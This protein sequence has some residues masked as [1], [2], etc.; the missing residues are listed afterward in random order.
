MKKIKLT[1]N[2]DGTDFRGF[3]F[4]PKLRTV[5]GEI[6]RSLSILTGEAIRVLGSGR[7]DAGVHANGQTVVF[8]TN[9]L[10][11]PEKYFIAVEQYLPND[12]SVIKSEEVD[13]NFH[14]IRDAKAKKYGYMISGNRIVDVR[15]KRFCYHLSKPLDVNLMNAACDK[16][17]GEQDFKAFC[18]SGDQNRSTIRTIFQAGVKE[19]EPREY[20]FYIIGDGFLY[21][22]VRIIVACLIE[23]GIKNITV[24]HFGNIIKKKNRALATITAQPQGLCLEKV[25]YN[26][27][28]LEKELDEQLCI[29]YNN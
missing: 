15:K 2:Y 3:Q 7:T 18:A 17:L 10:I 19:Y 13:S 29:E 12:I 16:L 22:M 25:W 8:D 9:C 27:E 23:V 26:K 5:Q 4:Q 11:P 28:F 21:K 14:P 20:Y 1:I 24:N 6:E